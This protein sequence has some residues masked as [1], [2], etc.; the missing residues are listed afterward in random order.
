MNAKRF[1]TSFKRRLKWYWLKLKYGFGSKHDENKAR[2]PKGLSDSQTCALDI[3]V[4]AIHDPA[5]KLY[6]DI[7]TQECYVKRDDSEVGTI[8]VFIESQNIK[9][10]NTVFGYDIFINSDT[11]NYITTV[12]RKEM[13]KRRA[14]FKKEALAKVD[15]SLHKV[16]DRINS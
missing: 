8:Y 10:I 5:S 3:A 11:E 9:I 6:Y 12:F 14:Q 15:H 2:R 16:L 7:T 4:K 13:A 1:L